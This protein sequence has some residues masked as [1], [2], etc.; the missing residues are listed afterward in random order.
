MIEFTTDKF[1]GPLGLLLNLIESEELDITEVSLAKIADDY[2]AYIRLAKNI[3]SE[4]LADFLVIAA[5]LLFIKS[6]ALLPYLFSSEEDEEIND[7]ERQLKMYQ[8]FVV[9]SEKIKELET[10]H[11]SIYLPPLASTKNRRL[12]AAMAIFSPPSYLKR[13]VLA[14]DNTLFLHEQFLR[15]VEGCRQQTQ[16]ILPEKKM[17]PEISIDDQI[18]NIK[19][20]IFN[21]IKVNF[22]KLIKAAATKTEVVVSFLAILELAKQQELFFEQVE[23]FGEIYISAMSKEEV[24]S[25]N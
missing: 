8:E 21:K 7:L 1:S 4:E 12:P 14:G 3:D 18:I 2:I 16:I 20:L 10:R 13:G 5:K 15:I 17:E 22:S 6:K 11:S 24:K 25:L 23:L 19:Q 9:A